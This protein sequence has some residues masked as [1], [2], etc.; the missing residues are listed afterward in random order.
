[1][2]VFPQPI[3]FSWLSFQLFFGLLWSSWISHVTQC[4]GEIYSNLYNCCSAD[5]FSENSQIIFCNILWSGTAWVKIASI[6]SWTRAISISRISN[7]YE[8][9]FHA[10]M[11]F[12][13]IFTRPAFLGP[14]FYTTKCV[15]RD[16]AKFTT[17][18]NQMLQNATLVTKLL[19]NH[20]AIYFFQII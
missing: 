11:I 8:M 14:K 2:L 9:K 10:D 3:L 18:Q 12:V 19:Y 4:Y 16:N 17:N 5:Y 6:L 1:M 20:Y 15:N 7:I 13:K